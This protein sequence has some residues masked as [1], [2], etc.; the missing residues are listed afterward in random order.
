MDLSSLLLFSCPGAPN[1]DASVFFI[2]EREIS[3]Q[4]LEHQT[5]DYT[6]TL[7]DGQTEEESER[8]SFFFLGRK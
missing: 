8:T 4:Q 3:Y 7:A 6:H 1:L 2:Y 5:L